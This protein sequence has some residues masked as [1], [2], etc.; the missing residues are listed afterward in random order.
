MQDQQI[1]FPRAGDADTSSAAH[2]DLSG[3]AYSTPKLTR[4]G[5]VS[6]LTAGGSSNRV[7]EVFNGCSAQALFVRC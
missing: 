4:F 1:A 6:A 5:S 7:S 2:E 3:S